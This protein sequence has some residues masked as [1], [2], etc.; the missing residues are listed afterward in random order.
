MRPALRPTRWPLTAKVPLLVVAL[1][2]GVAVVIGKVVLDRLASDQESNLR[3]LTNA[4]LDGLSTAV[5]PHVARRDVWET[6][7]TLDRA[8]T[9]LFQAGSRVNH[10]H[11]DRKAHT[12]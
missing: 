4:Y 1:M 3:L 8:P 10:G 6:F 11:A 12:L 2:I 9:L 5:L 7:D